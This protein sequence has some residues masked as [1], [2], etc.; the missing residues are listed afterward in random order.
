MEQRIALVLGGTSGV[1][2]ATARQLRERGTEVHVAGRDKRRVDAAVQSV[3]GLI[4]HQADATDP[5]ALTELLDAIGP[6]DWLVVTLSGGE[7]M[8]PLAELDL[9][10]LRRAFD[11]KFWA[12]LTAIKAALPRLTADGSI[13]LVGAITAR[14][15]MPGT[16]GLSALNAAVEGLVRPLAVELA[17]IRVNAVS[18]GF[19][20]TPWWSSMPDDAR[21]E[22]F[23]AAAAKLPTG[24]IAS[25][26]DVAEVV[27]LAATNPNVTGTVLE[28]DGGSKLVSMA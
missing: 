15:S 2:L 4:G 25:A 21:R 23:A 22:Y 24:R 1:G 12:H 20:D 13:T 11:A 26:E 5:A 10:A 27:T 17:P 6:L 18:P 19:V 14:S 7:G 3:E 9:S 16:A 28:T 8:G